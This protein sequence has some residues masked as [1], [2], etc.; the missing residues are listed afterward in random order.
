MP[1]GTGA[2]W[3]KQL[4]TG[5]RLLRNIRTLVGRIGGPINPAVTRARPPACRP[6]RDGP[7]SA[8][9]GQAIDSSRG[10]PTAA[11]PHKLSSHSAAVFNSAAEMVR[12]E[13][14]WER[15]GNSPRRA[16]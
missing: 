8:T 12:G 1:L 14:I 5:E 15:A 2:T 13:A 7:I 10:W 16:F 3:Q 4:Q 9:S 11:R 6:I